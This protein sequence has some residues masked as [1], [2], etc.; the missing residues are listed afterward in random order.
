MKHFIRSAQQAWEENQL[1]LVLFELTYACNLDCAF[2]YNDLDL[3][4]QPL[5]TQ[6]YIEIL[7]DLAEMQVL[8]VV[9]SGGEPLAHKDF[10][11]IGA[12][13]KH[14]GFV[15][16]IKSNAHALTHNI[17]KRIQREISPFIIETSL[18]GASSETHD[19][20]TKVAGS[21]DRWKRN[22]A[23]MLEIGLRVKVNTVLT[24]WNEH[25]LDEI[26]ALCDRFGV[27]LQI[28]REVKP[29]D[30]GDRSPLAIVASAKANEKLNTIYMSRSSRISNTPETDSAVPIVNKSKH[31]GTGSSTLTVNPFGDVFPCVQWR[32]KVA[33]LHEQ[34]V[35]EFW[36]HSPRL[37]KIREQNQAVRAKMLAL[38][39]DRKPPTFCPGLASQYTG[40]PLG[41]YILKQ[42][43]SELPVGKRRLALVT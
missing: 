21:F 24:R 6:R 1:R 30:N 5:S 2:C 4:G 25:E 34:L 23:D 16:R 18:H 12:A 9:L 32:Q 38:P 29:R 14:L 7:N 17:A 15:V 41:D 37:D 28:D 19:K 20:Q 10:F 22:V 13:A 8:T 40:D 36:H 42:D 31:C 11:T 39:S 26:F 35:S 27:L 43:Q 33:N 3:E